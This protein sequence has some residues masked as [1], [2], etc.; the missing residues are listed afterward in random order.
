VKGEGAV[1]EQVSVTF[2]SLLRRLRAEAFLT[3]EELADAAGLGLR[4][5]SD[6]ERGVSRTARIES[7]RLLA[8]ALGL[9]GEARTLFM[10]AARG[11]AEP[12]TLLTAG[13]G[14]RPGGFAAATRTLPRSIASFVGR[15]SELA[16]LDRA[17]TDSV[18]GGAVVAIHAIGGMAG[19]GKTSFAVHA[20]HQLAVRFP[21]GQFFLPL[22]AHTAG[23]RPVDPADA[24][25][26][27]LMTAGVLAHHIPPEAEA[28]AAVW[29]DYLAGKQIL[30]VLDDA[31]SHE[32]VRPLLPGTSGSLV[33]ITSRR[34][35]TALEDAAEISL[36][37]LSPGEAAALLARLSG[38]PELASGDGPAGE[39]TRLCGYLPL[40]IGML[41]RQLGQHRSWA[42]GDL[43]ARLACAR[44]RLGLMEA[45]N[46]SVAAAFD[47][48]YADLTP[49]QQQLFRRLGLV[50]GPDVDAYA[51]AALTGTSLETAWRNLDGLFGQHLLTEPASGRYLL[52][53]LLREHARALAA[54]DDQT[55]ADGA[56][57]ATDGLLDYYLYA[58]LAAGQHI[59]AYTAAQ[60]RPPPGRP[61]AHLPDVSTLARAV[62]WL[63]AER[64]NLHAAA[65]YAAA[66]GRHLH[67][68]QIPAAVGDFL[69]AHGDWD[70]ALE[71]HR[72]ALAAARDAGDSGG[73]AL[74]LRQLGIISWLKGHFGI[75]ADLLAQAADLYRATG[76][77]PGEAYA[78]NHLGRV[79]SLTADYPAAL[80]SRFRALDIARSAPNPL[81]EANVLAHLAETSVRTGDLAAASKYISAAL[82]IY[83]GQGHL[84]GEADVLGV[85]CALQYEAG[86]YAASAANARRALEIYRAQDNRP[87]QPDSLTSLGLAL[88]RMGDFDAAL[89][90]LTQ[91]LEQ[92]RN[93]GF[94]VGEA[95]ALNG[96]GELA[97]RTGQHT[98][99]R[100]HH[101]AALAIACEIGA[102]LEQAC[103]LE[104]IG[105]ASLQAGDVQNG[106]SNLRQALD[107]YQRIGAPAAKRSAEALMPPANG[108]MLPPRHGQ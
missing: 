68:V 26:S 94:K 23:Q 7:A 80:E 93:L 20:A 51:A 30:L 15:T 12:A 76:D 64:P 86:D 63:G 104:G 60:G 14:R 99:A 77:R 3:Q 79:Q 17:V 38:R 59:P 48:S 95:A 37:T 1:A 90:C 6:L 22:H 70:Q 74:A 28:R 106:V 25:A 24:L 87:F 55:G 46:I 72:T 89:A 108:P 57:A 34:R 62:A 33:L 53:D 45:E 32:Q 54:Q 81:A 19:I 44:D 31:A 27:L 58:A 91:A 11:R 107:I 78:L 13:G 4:S 9:A 29:R 5:V 21:D 56:G 43:A 2:G 101:R 41:A 10:A 35:M 50:P 105:L 52:H 39:I 42:P 82:E 65:D 8:D 61:P 40:A 98:Q 47:L 49:G 85:L 73:Q 97:R 67:A 71:L 75:A 92:F 96:L 18:A 66:S 103:A 84:L 36:D 16:D 83:R 100:D 88:Q 69:R 102:P